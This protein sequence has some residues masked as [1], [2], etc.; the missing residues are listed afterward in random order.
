MGGVQ[1]P[2]APRQARGD[3]GVTPSASQSPDIRPPLK[4]PPAHE[5]SHTPVPS[6]RP[7]TLPSA[8]G[9]TPQG[10]AGRSWQLAADGIC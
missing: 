6:P 4:G 3:F 10:Q 5:A 9:Q 1:F 8:H 2:V 7:G